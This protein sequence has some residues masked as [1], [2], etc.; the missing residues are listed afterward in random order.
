MQSLRCMTCN[1]LLAR[2]LGYAKVQIKCKKCKKINNFECQRV[3]NES[4]GD[5][6]EGVPKEE[7]KTG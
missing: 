7:C 1:A 5:I 6:R 4:K 3:P 2:V